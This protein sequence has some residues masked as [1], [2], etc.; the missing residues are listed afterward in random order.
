[1]TRPTW[2]RYAAPPRSDALDPAPAMLTRLATAIAS[3]ASQ[4][5]RGRG[6]LTVASPERRNGARL[7]PAAPVQSWHSDGI[8]G[9]DLWCALDDDG[10]RALLRVILGGPGSAT[11]TALERSIVREAVERLLSYTPC[12]WE[13]RDPHLLTP[14]SG[15][16]CSLTIAAASSAG[17][18]IT[19][20]APAAHETSPP[21][22]R[23]DLASIPLQL[24]AS[25]SATQVRVGAIMR[26]RTGDLVPLGC[27]AGAPVRLTV[28]HGRVASGVLGSSRGR[29]AIE[30]RGPG[31]VSPR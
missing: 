10:A 1:M 11:P 14:D 20:H 2:R 24:S 21:S 15:W 16:S 9:L 23:V 30:V 19:L 3:G 28:A 25:L 17:A 18:H 5:L 26:W 4:A 29:R 8:D 22:A 27:D 31:D 6:S 13:E 7:G 12:V